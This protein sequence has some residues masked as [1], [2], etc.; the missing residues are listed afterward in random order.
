MIIVMP[1][2]HRVLI[3]RST[4]TSEITNGGNITR[5]VPETRTMKMDEIL[6]DPHPVLVTREH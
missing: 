5:F 4:S 2:L 3:L 1:S 6:Q